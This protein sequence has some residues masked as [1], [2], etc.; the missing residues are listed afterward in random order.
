MLLVLLMLE[1]VPTLEREISEL[2]AVELT[3]LL[4]LLAWIT[5]E[6]RLELDSGVALLE[7]NTLPVFSDPPPPQAT[8]RLMALISVNLT[9]NWMANIQMSLLTK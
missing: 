3:L 2:V 7:L 6:L 5:L 8:K 4:M 1:L 9:G